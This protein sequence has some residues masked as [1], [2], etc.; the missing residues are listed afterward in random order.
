MLAPA[1]VGYCAVSH[2]HS[3]VRSGS[4]DGGHCGIIR[5]TAADE[6][7]KTTDHDDRSKQSMRTP[8]I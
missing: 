7:G 1:H 4:H 3:G 8:W 6:Y 2:A 5:M